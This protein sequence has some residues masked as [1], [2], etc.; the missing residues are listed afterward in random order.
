M[1]SLAPIVKTLKTALKSLNPAIMAAAG[2]GL[3]A[4]SGAIKAGIAKRASAQNF[5][6]GG[7][8]YGETFARLGE[9]PGARTNPEIVAPLDRLKEL[10]GANSIMGGEVIFRIGDRELVGIL[11]QANKK[12]VNF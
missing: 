3:I 4:I 9:Y 11:T 8:V 1:L 5:A 12:Q 2:I 10:V 6:N 7:V